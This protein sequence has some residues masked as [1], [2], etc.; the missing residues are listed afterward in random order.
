MGEAGE[1]WESAGK[2]GTVWVKYQNV[3]RRQ[4]RERYK[5]GRERGYES[6]QIRGEEA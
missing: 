5:G 6:V 2:C 3:G 1:V 4:E